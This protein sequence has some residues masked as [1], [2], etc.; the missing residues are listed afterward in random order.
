[1]QAAVD[2]DPAAFDA[3]VEA[4][5]EEQAAAGHWG[6][7]LFSFDGEPFWGQDRFD[8]LVWRLKQR[9]LSAA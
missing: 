4:H 7:P 6:V 3:Q 5:Q 8:L 1:M 9:G 2:A